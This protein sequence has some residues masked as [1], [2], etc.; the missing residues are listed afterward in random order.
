M[1]LMGCDEHA[2][3]ATRMACTCK[4]ASLPADEFGVLGS[5]LH[6]GVGGY[7]GAS[8]GDNLAIDNHLALHNPGLNDAPAVL[9]VS[10]KADLVQSPLLG[11]LHPSECIR[12][13]LS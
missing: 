1:L 4:I 6:G 7:R 8:F 2:R 11:R 10:L 12:L 3:L 5:D 9:R 13:C